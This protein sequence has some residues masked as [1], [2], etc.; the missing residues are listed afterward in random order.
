LQPNYSSLGGDLAS[1]AISNAYYPE[2]NRGT[3][4]VFANFGIGTG[5]RMLASLV[6]E[7][8][9]SKFTSRAKNHK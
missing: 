6:Q 3:G 2:S 9:L 4:L 5:E 7:F 1:A 8:I